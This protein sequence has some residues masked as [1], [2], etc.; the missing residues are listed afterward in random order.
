LA[1]GTLQQ[2]AKA[3][4]QGGKGFH[5]K[6]ILI[7]KYMPVSPAAEAPAKKKYICNAFCKIL[8]RMDKKRIRRRKRAFAPIPANDRIVTFAKAFLPSKRHL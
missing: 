8:W 6:S 5:T 1:G 4:E 3:A 7:I 2:Q